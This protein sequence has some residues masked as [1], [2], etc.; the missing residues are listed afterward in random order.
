MCAE[1]GD[2]GLAPWDALLALRRSLGL[3]RLCPLQATLV[4]SKIC[5]SPNCLL[6]DSPL[7]SF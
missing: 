2:G 5:L 1:A 4:S 6:P 7:P 3:Q